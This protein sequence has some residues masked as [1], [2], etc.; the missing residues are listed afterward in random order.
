MCN[1]VKSCTKH[2]RPNQSQQKET[3]VLRSS[4]LL[5]QSQGLPSVTDMDDQNEA[6][7]K[8]QEK[9][10]KTKETHVISDYRCR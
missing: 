6:E 9:W 2:G 5:E 1:Q 7:R 10:E 4:P 8:I 3:V